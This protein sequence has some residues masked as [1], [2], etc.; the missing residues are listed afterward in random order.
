MKTLDILCDSPWKRNCIKNERHHFALAGVT[1]ELIDETRLSTEKNM[2]ND[3]KLLADKGDTLEFL[4]RSG[5]TPVSV[6]S[7]F[8]SFSER[9]GKRKC[10][11]FLVA[12]TS[13]IWTALSSHYGVSVVGCML[14]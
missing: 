8:L 14:I 1:Q 12:P 7:S 2:L 10:W 3:L 9:L 6:S 13:K 5:E 11:G 4:G